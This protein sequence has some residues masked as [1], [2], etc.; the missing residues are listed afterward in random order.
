MTQKLK[1][2]GAHFLW[3]CG[4]W[5]KQ[6][7]QVKFRTE[8]KR[9]KVTMRFW[10]VETE[11]VQEVGTPIVCDVCTLWFQVCTGTALCVFF[12]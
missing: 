12:F 4:Q 5:F 9:E 1:K 10:K 2:D 3:G 7:T 11:S 6:N 8:R